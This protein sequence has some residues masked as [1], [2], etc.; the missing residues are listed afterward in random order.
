MYM[1]YLM[2]SYA[3]AALL[4]LV[5]SR[6]CAWSVPG[7]RGL[8][9]L[10]W[11]FL[12]GLV[13]VLLIAARPFTPAWLTILVS[14]QLMAG[15]VLL[16]YCTAASILDAPM[17]FLS[18]GLAAQ[19]AMLASLSYY[20]YAVPN[21]TARIVIAC[22]VCALNALA[23]AVLLFRY[24]EPV[25]EP[26]VE[27][28]LRSLTRVLAW[29]AVFIAAQNLARAILSVLYPSRDFLYLNL[30]QTAFTYIG[31]LMSAAAG[32]GLIWLALWMHRRDLHRLAQTD[33][34]TGLL[35]RRAFEEILASDL[36]R[37]SGGDV[38]AVLLA[39]IDHFKNVNDAWGHPAGDEV[40]RKVGWAMRK[41]C[42]PADV[43][44][45][46]G[47][48]E[49]IVLL[50]DVSLEQA[51]EIGERLRRRI[52][53][54]DG[55]PGKMQVTVSIGIAANHAV[56]TPDEL[57]RRCDMAMYCSKQA[58]RNLVTAY[59]SFLGR[60]RAIAMEPRVTA[61]PA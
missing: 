3:A 52:A 30:I 51:E 39:D 25:L 36:R 61:R 4:M 40:I 21:L 11:G 34:L 19:A 27:P 23:A 12:L 32:G 13:S 47:G 24:K 49:F 29:L 6:V 1:P 50:R 31:M 37:R 7:L 57:L 16:V 54:L 33:G 28:S 14:N 46:V 58:G 38:V 17:R 43:L 48:E 42:V 35:N 41:S 18:W 55:L 10:S 5:C 26:E 9:Y 45:R 20:T 2:L 22:C 15:F 44:A 8:N 56:D 60:S 53:C 59:S